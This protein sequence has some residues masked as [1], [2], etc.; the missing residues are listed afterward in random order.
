MNCWTLYHK[1]V[2]SHPQYNPTNL[3]IKEMQ[4]LLT[5]DKSGDLYYKLKVTC[6]AHIC[7]TVCM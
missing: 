4:K 2:Y 5:A 1:S 3:C 7:T 6:L